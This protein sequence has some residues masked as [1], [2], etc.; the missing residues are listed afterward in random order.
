MKKII[1]AL[2]LAAAFI[3]PAVSQE[4]EKTTPIWDHGDNVSP[5]VYQNV[6]IFK[7][8]DSPDAYVVLYEMAGVKTG[9]A[10]IPKKWSRPEEKG[11]HSK[12]FIRNK[13]AG[14]LG[15]YMTVINQ[16]GKFLKVWL[17]IPA[18]RSDPMWGVL[19]LGTTIE[20]TDA[21]ELNLQY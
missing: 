17:T 20:G 2:I 8:Y 21:D 7:V 13:P 18:S 1:M 10:V 3:L 4:K 12:L 9:T 11:K 15:P 19:P 14:L 5:L 6:R 16:D